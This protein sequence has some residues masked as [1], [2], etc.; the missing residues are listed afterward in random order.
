MCVSCCPKGNKTVECLTVLVK[1]LLN[2]N[3]EAP[4]TSPIAETAWPFTG[5]GSDVTNA[6]LSP[7]AQVTPVNIFH[8]KMTILGYKINNAAYVTDCSGLPDK[9]KET[10]SA[11]K[12]LAEIS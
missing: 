3:V 8:G 9:T 6:P 11:E 4:E 12:A 5:S 2:F 1:P 7:G 10:L